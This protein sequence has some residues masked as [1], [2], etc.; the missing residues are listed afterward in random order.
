MSTNRKGRGRGIIPNFSALKTRDRWRGLPGAR[1]RGACVGTYAAVVAAALGLAACEQMPQ[2]VKDGLQPASADTRASAEL[3]PSKASVASAAPGAVRPSTPPRSLTVS[4]EAPPDDPNLKPIIVK[5]PAGSDLPPTFRPPA[6]ATA[7]S[8]VEA[9]DVTLNFV[10]TDIRDVIAAVLGE[11]LKLNYVIDA[12]I[13]G[14]MTFSVSRALPRDTVLPAFE[15]VLNSYGATMIQGDGIIHVTALRADGKLRMAVPIGRPAVGRRIEVF[16]LRYITAADMQGV[17]ERVLPPGHVMVPDDTHQ[18]LLVE[19]APDDLRVV[20]DTVRIFDIDRLSGVSVGLVPLKNADA[21]VLVAELKNIFDFTRKDGANVIRFSPVDRLNAVMIVTRQPKYLDEAQNWIARLDRTRNADEPSLFVYSLQY[22]KAATVART[23]QGALSGLN[24]DL[25]PTVTPGMPAAELPA[26]GFPSPP[27]VETAP[28]SVTILPAPPPAQTAPSAGAPA[29]SGAPPKTPVHIQADEAHNSLIISATPRDYALIRQ[30]LE[31]VDVPP[32]QVLIEVTVAEVV[33]NN[34][35]RFGVQY[36]IAGGGAGLSSRSQTILTNG[37]STTGISPTVPGFS[38]SLTNSDFSP[39]VI[40]SAL[41]QLTQTKVISTPRLLVL[42][43]QTARLQVG[44]VVPI[45]T[46]SAASTVTNTPLVLSN[47]QYKETGVVL[48]VTPRINSG[49]VVTMDVN[50]TV[51]D[52]QTTTSS[53]INSPTIRQR[54][55]TSTISVASEDSIL[56]GGLIQD[57]DNRD[58]SGIPFLSDIPIL[59]ALFGTRNNSSGRTELIIFLTPHVL[60][61][62][63]QVR[64][65]TETVR[66]QF[67]D[68]LDRSKLPDVKVAP[69]Y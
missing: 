19:G 57:Q 44:D 1:S 16:P 18:L 5:A 66:R 59:G 56:L 37:T 40:L 31:G 34:N 10:N 47:I 20:E 45:L 53:T 58:T 28:P 3:V 69:R 15:A 30:V 48:E 12:N 51:S 21:P 62:E 67:Q 41:S 22:G 23:L 32:L 17:L 29:A 63:D 24:I 42:D 27:P 46:Q 68:L 39:H 50:Q 43:N 52:V 55:L 25:R 61:N 64:D 11:A 4:P 9:G 54:R 8:P 36:F 7:A 65:V 6:E 13:T 26:P 35:L 38:F 60:S 33:L 2:W 49:G 14:P